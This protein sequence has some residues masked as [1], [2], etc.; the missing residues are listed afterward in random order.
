M[1]YLWKITLKIQAG[2]ADLCAS[3]EIDLLCSS[4]FLVLTVG[5][6]DHDR[7]NAKEAKKRRKI[8]ILMSGKNIKRT[9]TCTADNVRYIDT[10]LWSKVTRPMVFDYV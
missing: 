7:Q 2:E 5:Q 6:H 9:F 1:V 8:K 3:M 10:L 4:H